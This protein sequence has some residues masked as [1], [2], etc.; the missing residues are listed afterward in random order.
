MWCI[1]QITPEYRDRMYALIDL[2]EQ[3][4]DK[5]YPVVCID[6]KEQAAFGRNLGPHRNEAGKRVIKL[7]TGK[8]N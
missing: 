7:P 1:G 2:Y 3:E 4:Y 5:F 8:N 6:E